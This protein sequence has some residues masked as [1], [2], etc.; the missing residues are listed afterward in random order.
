[1]VADAWYE[2]N[3]PKWADATADKCRTYLDK[4]I[5]PALGDRLLHEISPGDTAAIIEIIE[6]R[7]AHNIAKKARQWLRRI[8]SFAIAK[9]FTKENPASELNEIAAPA[10]ASKPYPF[11]LEEELP[12][13]L[14]AVASYRGSVITVTASQL[15][16]LTA[17]R[18]GVEM[19]KGNSCSACPMD[20]RGHRSLP[21]TKN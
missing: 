10:P 7:D 4:D 6:R 21:A 13:F 14:R 2:F 19:D 18:P 12:N 11:L 8:F 15:V 9:G 20:S 1:M 5:L 17:N 16:I 3:K